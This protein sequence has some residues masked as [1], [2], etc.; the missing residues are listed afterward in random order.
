MTADNCTV[1]MFLTMLIPIPLYFSVYG[2]W[3]RNIPKYRKVPEYKQ[4]YMK[5]E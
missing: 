1:H 4:K 5:Q 2:E 3:T